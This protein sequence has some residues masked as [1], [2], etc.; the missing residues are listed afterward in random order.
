MLCKVS[1]ANEGDKLYKLDITQPDHAALTEVAA[2]DLYSVSFTKRVLKY[3]AVPVSQKICTDGSTEFYTIELSQGLHLFTCARA[4]SDALELYKLDC[5]L[6]K[7][8]YKESGD[9]IKFGADGS[10][11]RITAEGLATVEHVGISF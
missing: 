3:T 11:V 4:S 8:I 7:N 9:K 1:T 2:T 5:G 10:E 6:L